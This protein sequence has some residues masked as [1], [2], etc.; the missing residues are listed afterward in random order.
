MRKGVGVLRERIFPRELR[1]TD[2]V[3]W[4]IALPCVLENLLTF[5][6]TLVIAAMIG[7]LTADEISAQTIGSRITGLF[8]SLFKGIGVGG[9]IVVGTLYGMGRRGRCRKT[10]EELMLA[11]LAISIVVCVVVTMYPRPFLRLF[12]D[13]EDLIALAIPYVRVAVW[14]IPSFAVSRVITAAFNGEGNTRTPMVIAVTMNIINAIAGYILIFSISLGLMGAAWSLVAS[15]FCGMCMGMA[16][17]YCR[18]G[19]YGNI[20]ADAA[21]F[22]A[23]LGDVRSSFSTGLPASCEN[24]MWS[25]VAI[26]MS[27]VLLSYDTNSLAGYQ[28]ASQIEEFLASPC[29]GFQLAATTLLAQSQGR[30]DEAAARAYYRRI[31]FWAVVISLTPVL[32][33]TL[34][35]RTC[36]K[37]VTD[38]PLIQSVGAVYLVMAGLAYIPQTLNMVDFGAIRVKSSKLL[39][40]VV[41]VI[42]MWGV[43]VPIAAMSAWLFDAPI[44]VVFGG[45]ALDQFVRWGIALI[46]RW[47]KRLFWGKLP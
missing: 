11:S 32:V 43:R 41:T 9:T 21:L 29:F 27:R 4:R 28:L 34:L 24:M 3:I 42:G 7:R 36:M 46:Y 16:A 33:L 26:I 39:P 15:N 5:A 14:M 25:A 44:T 1:E 12:G 8:Q 37:I 20:K 6:A 40:L 38:K 45:I 31:S 23:G 10:T 19:L 17:L 47:R 30:C 35:P 13:D 2:R 22:R 18:R